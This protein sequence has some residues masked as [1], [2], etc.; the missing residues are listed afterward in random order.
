MP[1]LLT[2]GVLVATTLAADTRP[3]IQELDKDIWSLVLASP[4]L[5]PAARTSGGG[6]Q[7]L[8]RK[9]AQFRPV[10]IS[11]QTPLAPQEKEVLDLLIAASKHLDPIFNRQVWKGYEELREELAADP[12]PL[13]Q[14]TF[15]KE[16]KNTSA[17]IFPPGQVVLL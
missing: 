16:R 10:V 14:V 2:L 3:R 12:S 17:Y 11:S 9:I 13:S 7:E 6:L 5:V 4:G 15:L 1:L 8:E